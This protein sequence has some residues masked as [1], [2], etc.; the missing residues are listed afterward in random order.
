[1]GFPQILDTQTVIRVGITDQLRTEFY[2]ETRSF[3]RS[4]L[5]D[6]K[7]L[8]TLLTANYTYLNADLA[9]HY[10]VPGVTGTQFQRASLAATQRV[11]FLSHASILSVQ[12]NPADSRPVARGHYILEQV[13]CAPPPPPPGNINRTLPTASDGGVLTVRER[14]A[15]HRSSNTC[16]ACHDLMD[17]LGL[18]EENFDQLGM[19]RGAYTTG[20]S[21]DASGT[22]MGQSF[23]DFGGMTQILMQ[24][25]QVRSCIANKM[26]TYALNRV[27]TAGETPL[28]AQVAASA[29][30]D[31][32]SFIDLLFQVVTSDSFNF[33]STDSHQ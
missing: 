10:G 5:D 15:L 9:T 3:L 22:L 11:G 29:V 8:M 30:Q 19:Y 6:D 23:S 21:I 25:P 1:L 17:P 33:N 26:L 14:L 18:S 12:S 32:S 27:L 20:Q 2:E 7:S 31:T 13:L 16:A 24:A 28:P 4:I